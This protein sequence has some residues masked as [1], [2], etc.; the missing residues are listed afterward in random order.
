[1]AFVERCSFVTELSFAW[2][3]GVSG[4]MSNGAKM[5]PSMMEMSEYYDDY[6]GDDLFAVI[7]LTL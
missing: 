3:G 2:G 4:S 5:H 1:M 7:I 6:A